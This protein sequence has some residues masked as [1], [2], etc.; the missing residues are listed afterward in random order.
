M[1]RTPLRRGFFTPE[2]PTDEI[3]YSL[4]PYKIK[5]Y[6]KRI[7]IELCHQKSHAYQ[8]QYWSNTMTIITGN[9]AD[10]VLKG[11]TDDDVLQ[12]LA[13]VDTLEGKGGND[14]LEGGDGSDMAVYDGSQPDYQLELTA[15]QHL[16]VSDFNLADGNEGADTL[17]EIETVQFADRAWQVWQRQETQVNTSTNSYQFMSTADGLPDGGY[18]VTWMSYQNG[19]T[20]DIYGQRYDRYGAAAGG[21]FLV[22]STPASHRE[23]PTIASL[24][25]GGFVVTWMSDGQDGSGFGCYGQRFDSSGVIQGAEFQINTY[26]PDPQY[27]PVVA[28]LKDGGFAVAWMSLNQDGS[29]WG[30]YSQRFDAQALKSGGGNFGQRASLWRAIPARHHRPGQRR[31]CGDVDVKSSGWFG[32]RHLCS[33][34]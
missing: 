33:P 23:Y 24:P 31:I 26:V 11:T 17:Q 18:V 25:D 7:D 5:A 10:N 9:T 4:K 29:G 1:I 28:G 13:G 22:S 6:N 12:G 8:A 2:N 20:Y 15:D 27:M 21:E 14:L 32:L 19:A 30:V 3:H 16:M 34:V